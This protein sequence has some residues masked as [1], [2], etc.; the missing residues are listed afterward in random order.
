MCGITGFIDLSCQLTNP[1]LMSI[2]TRMSD[3]IRHRGPDDVGTWADAETGVALGFRRLAILDLSPT[4]HQ[5]MLS[6]DGRYVIIYN[7]EIYNFSELRNELGKLGHSFRGTSDTEVMLAAF[8]QWGIESA[9]KRFNG[10]FAFAVW[11]RP[12][13]QLTLGRDRLGIKPLFYGWVDNTFMFGS[14]LK[15]L[16]ANPTFRAEINRDALALYLRYNCIPAPYTIYQGIAKL[17]PGSLLKVDIQAGAVTSQPE[18]YWSARE[19][20]ERGTAE[21]FKGDEKEATAELDRLLRESVR[22]RMI[23]DVPLGAFLS[24]GVDSSTI[25]AM[26]QMQSN[27]P[28][29]TFSIGFNEADYNEAQYAKTVARHL[30]T[31]HTELYV[32][33]KETIDVIPRLPTLYDEPFSDS[34]QIPTFLVSQL[35]RRHVTVSLSGDGGDELFGGYNRYYWSNVIWRSIGWLPKWGRQSTAWGMS[36]LSPENWQ[37]LSKRLNWLIPKN[38]RYPQ[39]ADKIQKLGEIIGVKTPQAMYQGFV[40]HW[41]DP[42]AVVIDAKEPLNMLTDQSR[43][44]ILPDFLRWMMFMDLVSYLPD[45]ILVKVDRASMGVSLETRVPFL[46]D[47]QVVEFAWQIPTAMKIHKRQS[48]WLLRQVLYQ[49]VPREMIE[50]PKMG[51]GVPIDHW[52]RGPLR[53]WAEALLDENRL[54]REGYFNAKP[55]RDKWSEHLE[56]LHNWQYYLWDILMFQAWL[57]ETMI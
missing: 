35:A 15:T 18:V 20:A 26:M 12:E 34:S 17:P 38:S 28:V 36:L 45:D 41:K 3:Q 4:G 48:K 11:D 56:G 1:E 16:R 7:G 2:V 31:D 53:E 21:P 51:F 32:T 14:E 10:M 8:T 42:A 39:I 22:L 5:P 6:T 44:A 13:R 9:V 57:S 33:P 29:R 23:A 25:V 40:S 52:L 47:H 49:Y 37:T 24:G 54:R 46:D 43:W 50:R 19:I 55:I 27:I 30:G